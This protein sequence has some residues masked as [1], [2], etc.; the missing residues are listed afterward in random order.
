MVCASG[1]WPRWCERRDD[2]VAVAEANACLGVTCD[3]V[4][5]LVDDAMVLVAEEHEVLEA[6]LAAVRPVLAVVC[7]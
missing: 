4:A 2:A 3:G 5:A 7:L 1:R 6:R